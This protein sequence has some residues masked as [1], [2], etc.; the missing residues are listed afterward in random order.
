MTNHKLQELLNLILFT[1]EITQETD[2]AHLQ[3]CESFD[4]FEKQLMKKDIEIAKLEGSIKAFTS[5]I[6]RLHDDDCN[7][8]TC[9]G[10]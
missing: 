6:R 1:D 10:K 5:E 8:M 7:C 9:E 2:N 4:D 3:I